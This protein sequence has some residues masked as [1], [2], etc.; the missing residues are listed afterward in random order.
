MAVLPSTNQ[1]KRKFSD[2]IDYARPVLESTGVIVVNDGQYG[3]DND[4]SVFMNVQGMFML[5]IDTIRQQHQR[6]NLMEAALLEAGI[7]VPQ[8]HGGSE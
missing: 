1:L 3:N 4:G 8:L 5:T 7:K 2:W 6:M